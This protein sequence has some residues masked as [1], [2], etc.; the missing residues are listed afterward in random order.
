MPAETLSRFP[1]AVIVAAQFLGTSLWFSVNGVG[2]SLGQ[3][4]GLT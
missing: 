2:L 1:L 4:L 3:E